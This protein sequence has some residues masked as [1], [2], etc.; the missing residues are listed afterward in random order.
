MLLPQVLLA[1]SFPLVGSLITI[2]QPGNLIGWV[3]LLAGIAL[4]AEGFL[5][6]Y[7]ELALLAKPE[8]A[9]LPVGMAAAAIGMG[10]W[11]LLMA[12][13][14]LLLLLFPSGKAP[15]RRWGMVARLVLLAFALVWVGIAT[16]P[17]VDPPFENLENPLAFSSDDSYLGETWAL[18]GLCLIAV[19]VAAINLLV[20]FWRSTGDE[21]EQYKWLAFAGCF[22]IASLPPA[23]A[24]SFESGIA[25]VMVF[26]ALIA[27]PVAVG[28]AVLKYRLYEINVLINRT[29]VYVPL[30][31]ILAG[32][33]VASTTLIRTIFTD[34]TQTGPAKNKL[35]AFVDRYFKETS[36]P[37]RALA[38]LAAET[39]SVFS[40]IDR[41]KLVDR[42]L[43]A[44]NEAVDACGAALQ[45]KNSATPRLFTS[46]GW[47]G[48]TA[49]MVPVRY[50][51]EEVGSLM[52]GPSRLGRPY[53]AK[54]LEGLRGPIDVLA[55]ALTLCLAPAKPKDISA[56]AVSLSEIS[57]DP[58]PRAEADE[59]VGQA[60]APAGWQAD[61]A[62]LR[63]KRP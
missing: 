10:A 31:A 29:L 38:Q 30:T 43:E 32:L 19:A 6:G 8:E 28:I 23:L 13:V 57:G 44:T 55:H 24:T 52:I 1:C 16:S 35:Q 47:T 9:S 33:F 14:F 42:F 27:L 4:I 63:L 60:S 56:E 21:R 15:S 26:L 62:A 49:A 18:I 22:M 17:T 12:S 5:R 48:E 39:S 46:P 51:D 11:T 58:A 45:V 59:G 25:S 37:V 50:E 40:L 34:L 3:L 36:E 61:A 2:R 7:G 53:E 54:V 20:R 41:D